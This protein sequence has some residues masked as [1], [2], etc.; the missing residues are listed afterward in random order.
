MKLERSQ[1]LKEVKELFPELI[2][3]INLEG[4]LSTFEM[5]A[6]CAFTQKNINAGEKE[7]V[8]MCFQIVEKY[9]K[10]SNSKF[11]DVISTCFVECLDFKNTKKNIREWAWELF[12]QLLKEDYINFHGK[13]GI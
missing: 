9:Y 7:T 10:E 11:K 13:S 2:S 1:F 5:D 6:F 4:G 12:P 3:K 8:I